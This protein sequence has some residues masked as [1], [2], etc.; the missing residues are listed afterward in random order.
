[1]SSS[2]QIW[3]QQGW[4]VVGY[5]YPATTQLYTIF[6]ASTP[7]ATIGL[8]PASAN[9]SIFIPNCGLYETTQPPTLV[10]HVLLV[11]SIDDFG[12][13]L[14]YTAVFEA[15]ST[16]STTLPYIAASPSTPALST[17]TY[18]SKQGNWITSTTLQT[19]QSIVSIASVTTPPVTSRASSRSGA[20]ATG[21]GH[22]N[23]SWSSG[24]PPP[25]LSDGARAGIAVGLILAVLLLIGV[26]IIFRRRH[27]TSR[28]TADQVDD[29]SIKRASEKMAVSPDDAIFPNSGHNQKP[30]TFYR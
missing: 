13:K 18:T 9:G 1:M 11:V 12:P 21:S 15:T 28:H 27:K 17:Q 24:G 10:D 14:A 22:S 19:L 7:I 16:I 4:M 3:A 25:K 23:I 29:A 2:V 5:D 8:L 26:Y 30:F 6:A 20:N